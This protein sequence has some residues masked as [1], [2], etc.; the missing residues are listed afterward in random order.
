MYIVSCEGKFFWVL[1][2]SLDFQLYSIKTTLLWEFSYVDL[3]MP[4]YEGQLKMLRI[5]STNP[6]AMFVLQCKSVQH[7][8]VIYNFQLQQVIMNQ[9]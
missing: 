1:L 7:V 5:K 3:N 6:F 2:Y 9:Y 4:L 8:R